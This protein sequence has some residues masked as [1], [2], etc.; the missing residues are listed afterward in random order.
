MMNVPEGAQTI[1]LLL[2]GSIPKTKLDG[3]LTSS[4]IHDIIVEHG[5]H[6]LCRSKKGA[7]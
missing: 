5:G 1:V 3:L 4:Q 6:I 7:H 2:T